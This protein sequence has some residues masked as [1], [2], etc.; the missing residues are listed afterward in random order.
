MIAGGVEGPLESILEVSE[1]GVVGA[2]F[3][4]DRILMSSGA[5]TTQTA[6]TDG[7]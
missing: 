3:F 6:T 1:L 4:F 7:L 2:E 5:A